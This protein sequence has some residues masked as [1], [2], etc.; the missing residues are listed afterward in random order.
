M[1]G[2]FPSA[3]R[4]ASGVIPIH[5]GRLRHIYRAAVGRVDGRRCVADALQRMAPAPP[6]V[7][8]AI[9]K[10]SAA[11]LQGA[12]DVLGTQVR[13]ALM[14]AKSGYQRPLP[15][16]HS[17][18]AGHP[19]PDERSVEAGS[20][21]LSMLARAPAEASLLFLISGGASALVECPRPGISLQDLQR[22]NRWLLGC[23]M[24]IHAVN[25]VRASLS[26]IKGGRLIRYLG[27]RRALNW[28]ISDV[29][30]DD[31]SVIGSGLLMPGLGDR[32]PEQAC[33]PRWLVRLMEGATPP[34]VP[35]TAVETLILARPA[36]AR[37]AAAEE[38]RRLGY[39]VVEHVELLTGD[40]ETAGRRVVEVLLS[41]PPALHVWSGETTVT[42]PQRPGVG[43]R[44]Q[45]L[46]LSAAGAM[47]GRTGLCLL[48]AG[49]DG[50][51]G[52]TEVA[53][54]LVD[55]A[56]AHR[57]ERAGFQLRA[58]LTGADAGSFLRASGDLVVTGPTGTNVM[59]LMLGLRLP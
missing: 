5:R 29:P 13:E 55:E 10:A 40:A 32:R 58:A 49:T 20:A 39:T 51:D 16:V 48:A 19:Y 1:P 17:L 54:A 43:G 18:Q 25:H 28:L 8:V 57:G 47:R 9:G 34:P 46:A 7:A 41:C 14:V 56:T 6:V 4:T 22:V 33:F 52:P 27:G 50:G 45:H 11:M 36:D 31:P 38:G 59:D 12:L 42:L 37:S 15:G 35:S 24:G 21:V 44:C 30:G 23:G 53:G 2:V 26:L 3:P